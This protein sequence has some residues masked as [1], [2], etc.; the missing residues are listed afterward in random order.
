MTIMTLLSITNNIITKLYISYKI[1]LNGQQPP[2]KSKKGI[3]VPKITNA[4]DFSSQK[5]KKKN[6]SCFSQTFH[7]E[8]PF[9]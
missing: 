6:R 1:Q 2:K 4:L 5:L 3:F 8:S 9:N 7:M